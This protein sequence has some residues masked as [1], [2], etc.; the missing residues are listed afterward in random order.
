MAMS[1]FPHEKEPQN[2]VFPKNSEEKSKNGSAQGSNEM[3]MTSTADSQEI[4]NGVLKDSQS[5]AVT[6]HETAQDADGEP[7][8]ER[9]IELMV[10]GED[11]SVLTTTQKKLVILTVSLASLFSPM[12]TAIY[13]MSTSV[14]IFC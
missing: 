1:E 2:G 7:P 3:P 12:A 4:E 5:N 11:Y 6:T 8:S 14:I 10:S 13:C 9:P